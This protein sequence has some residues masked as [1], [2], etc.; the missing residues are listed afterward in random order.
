LL[1]DILA[2]HRGGIKKS[3]QVSE[4]EE[5]EVEVDNTTDRALDYPYIPFPQSK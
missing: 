4:K 1:R 2:Q 5:A 3:G